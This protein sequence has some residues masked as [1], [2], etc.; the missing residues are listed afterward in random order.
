MNELVPPAPAVAEGA[1][2]VPPRE[3]SLLPPEPPS[4]VEEELAL[5]P[6]PD[7]VAPAPPLGLLVDKPAV[8]PVVVSDLPPVA[9]PELSSPV[10]SFEACMVPPVPPESRTPASIER[11]L[12]CELREQLTLPAAHASATAQM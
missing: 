2:V 7:V 8:P 9:P 6:V 1:V 5:L 3:E 4:V 10:L 12:P 11:L